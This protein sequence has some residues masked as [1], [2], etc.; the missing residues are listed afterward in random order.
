MGALYSIVKLTSCYLP[1]QLWRIFDLKP[2]FKNFQGR[3]RE[4]VT[5]FNDLDKRTA[6][7]QVIDR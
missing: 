1:K 5:D 4:N 3:V 2:T 7:G 6:V